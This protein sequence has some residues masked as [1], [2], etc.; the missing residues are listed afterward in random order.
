MGLNN[1]V[2]IGMPG[3]GKSTVGAKLAKRLRYGL[4][5]TDRLLVEKTG[6]PLPQILSERG[7]DGLI[8]AEGS[9]G[10]ELR[11][12]H[13][14]IATGGSM[15]F[16][17]AAMQNLCQGNT[18]IWLDTN[19]AELEKRIHRSTDRGIAAVPGTTVAQLDAVRRPL[20]QKYANIRV[21]TVGGIERV[22]ALILD[23]LDQFQKH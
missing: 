2:L 8:A 10:A 13:C 21:Q 18:V 6:I 12:E 20:Y 14:V 23:A 7:V 4:I 5:D 22:V 19:I 16:S 17:D 1:I 11:C 3:T 9:I 15:V